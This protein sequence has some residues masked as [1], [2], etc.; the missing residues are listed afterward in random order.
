MW[1]FRVWAPAAKTLAVRTGG[2]DHAMA[3]D[4]GGWWQAAIAEAI[5]P[6]K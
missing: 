4:G 6:M 2:L 1:T 5:W 3:S